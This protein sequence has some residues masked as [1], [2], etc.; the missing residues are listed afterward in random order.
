MGLEFFCEVNKTIPSENEESIPNAPK[1]NDVPAMGAIKK[2]A[3]RK[4]KI[5]YVTGMSELV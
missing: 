1:S 2:N 3:N 5:K 4:R